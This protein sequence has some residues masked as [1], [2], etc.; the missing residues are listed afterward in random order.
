MSRFLLACLSASL[1][2]S[3]CSLDEESIQGPREACGQAEGNLLGCE[4]PTIETSE[5][6]CWRLVGCGVIPLEH[7]ENWV[8]DWKACVVLLDSMNTFRHDLSLSC[9]ESST[10]EQLKV[11]DQSPRTPSRG[12]DNLPLCLQPGDL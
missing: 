7:E 6:A 9:V 8:L 10:C 4:T 2:L 1:L 3:G 12:G 11:D 5:D